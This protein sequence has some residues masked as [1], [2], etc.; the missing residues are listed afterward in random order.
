M[1]MEAPLYQGVR[2][3]DAEEGLM[4]VISIVVGTSTR[5]RIERIKAIRRAE[6]FVVELSDDEIFATAVSLYWMRK[7]LSHRNRN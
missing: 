7:E 4:E 1:G 6:G 5:R 2:E 3:R